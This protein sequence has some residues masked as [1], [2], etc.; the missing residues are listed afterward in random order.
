ME[1]KLLFAIS[2]IQDR[3]NTKIAA[4]ADGKLTFDQLMGSLREEGSALTAAAAAGQ[5]SVATSR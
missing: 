2:T 4:H 3:I 5:V 1:S